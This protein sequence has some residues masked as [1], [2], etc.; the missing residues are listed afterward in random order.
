MSFS[1]EKTKAGNIRVTL[2]MDF[3]PTEAAMLVEDLRRDPT[4]YRTSM[5]P[6]TGRE[7]AVQVQ[8][9]LAAEVPR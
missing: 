2:V 6:T 5:L 8:R 9:A 7:L 3:H 1:A 4:E